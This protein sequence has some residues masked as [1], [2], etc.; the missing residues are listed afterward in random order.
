MRWGGCTVTAVTSSTSPRRTP[1]ADCSDPLGGDVVTPHQENVPV[2]AN[3]VGVMPGQYI[4]A[5]GAG[6]VVIPEPQV[7]E[8]LKAALTIEAD[9]V[10]RG[11]AAGEA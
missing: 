8:V 4:Y 1:S 6:A 11:E 9:E 10:V 7:R 3:R 2:V 5:D